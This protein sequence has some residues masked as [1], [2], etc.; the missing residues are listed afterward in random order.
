MTSRRV[1]CTLLLA[2]ACA[3]CSGGDVA[4]SGGGAPPS[5]T[6]LTKAEYIAQADV[7]CKQARER[8]IA[9]PSET[10]LLRLKLYN[11]AETNAAIVDI[12]GERERRLGA[13]PAP[14]G[15]EAAVAA[16]AAQA[17]RAIELGNRLVRRAREG[18]EGAARSAYRE[19]LLANRERLRLRQDF[20]FSDCA[21]GAPTPEHQVYADSA[22][23]ICGEIFPRLNALPPPEPVSLGSPTLRQYWAALHPLLADLLGRLRQ[24]PPPADLD[25]GSFLG[26]LDRSVV[27]AKRLASAGDEATARRLQGEFFRE[28]FDT[29]GGAVS[30]NLLDCTGLLREPVA[31]NRFLARL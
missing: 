29:L 6:R 16:I 19:F 15:E 20:G 30:I 28:F 1:A 3:S 23:A 22:D 21:N 17:A 18:D 26:P 7:I 9:L 2:L 4:P 12:A 27:L 31:F 14:Q 11:M 10:G 13:L 5:A 25:V 24:V 8:I